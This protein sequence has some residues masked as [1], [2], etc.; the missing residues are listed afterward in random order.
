MNKL[1]KFILLFFFTF[2]SVLSYANESEWI[3]VSNSFSW[4]EINTNPQEI[5]ISWETN[6]S[7]S[8]QSWQ[9]ITIKDA[10]NNNPIK[11]E[12]KEK[13]KEIETQINNLNWY[14]DSNNLQTDTIN[15]LIINLSDKLNELDSNLNSLKTDNEKIWKDN[16]EALANSKRKIKIVESE[17]NE[18]QKT[19]ESYKNDLINLNKEKF[20]KE[21]YLKN[22]ISIKQEYEKLLE[23]KQNEKDSNLLFFYSLYILIWIALIFYFKKQNQKGHIITNVIFSFFFIISIIISFF[24]LYPETIIYL[25]FIAS[26]LI[27]ISKNL[28]VSIFS[29]IFLILKHKIWDIIEIPSK[30]LRWKIKSISTFVTELNLI[31][32]KNNFLNKTVKIPNELI[33]TNLVLKEQENWLVKDSFSFTLDWKTSYD[34]IISRIDSFLNK[35]LKHKLKNIDSESKTYFKRMIKIQE[36]KVVIIYNWNEEVENLLFIKEWLVKILEKSKLINTKEKE[37]QKE[38]KKNKITKKEDLWI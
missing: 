24:Y 16:Q 23:K 12:N 30:E 18:L 10:I 29:S 26:A 13:I 14:L 20:E 8:T 33:F 19:I 27:I 17:K 4:T 3:N 31:D 5:P 1:F 25:I 7:N 15:K 9:I 2:I 28:I 22:Y 6:T 21:Q 36:W 32:D 37:D 35:N 34:T 38:T 11:N